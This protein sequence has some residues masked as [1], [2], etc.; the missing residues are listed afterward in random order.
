[1]EGSFVLPRKGSISDPLRIAVLISGGGSGLASIIAYEKSGSRFFRTVLVLADS[2][3]A[4]GL[5]HGEMAGVE[6]LGVPLPDIESKREQ[7][8][9]HEKLIQTFLERRDVEFIALAGYMRILTPGFVAK[10]NGR[11][12]NIHPSLLPKYP[13]AH[14]HRDA[15]ADGAMISGCT[16]HFVDEGVDTGRI[17]D[18]TEV[19]VLS[20]DRIEDL[21]ERVKIAEHKLYPRVID[22]LAMNP[23]SFL[24]R[25]GN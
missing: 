17:I 11:L 2:N 19:P 18:Q 24:G 25:S 20:G 3:E 12:V 21:Q 23:S 1:M 14:A 13:G 8:L 4:G 15:L 5:K 6:S 16:V 10:W 9:Y 7:R 22:G